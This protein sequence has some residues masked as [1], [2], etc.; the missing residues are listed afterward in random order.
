M[1]HN[2]LIQQ[3]VANS[4]TNTIE[5]LVEDL[6]E[7]FGKE[8]ERDM[9]KAFTTNTKRYVSLFEQVIHDLMPPR[10]IDPEGDEVIRL[11]LRKFAMSSKISSTTNDGRI[12]RILNPRTGRSS[13]SYHLK[14]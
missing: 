10:T 2:R 9:V 4:L 13:R 6:R 12:W 1:V 14:L 7:Y 11:P 5:I 3:N 8:D